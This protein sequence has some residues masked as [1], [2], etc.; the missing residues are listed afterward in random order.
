MAA[1]IASAVVGLLIAALAIGI[2]QLINR[3]SL[4]SRPE[5]MFDRPTYERVTGRSAED[6]KAAT[7][8]WDD[9]AASRPGG[10]SPAGEADDQA[11]RS[12]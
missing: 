8:T 10:N 7:P 5:D 6:I 1:G 3:R 9:T 11:R 12:R 2:P 4:R